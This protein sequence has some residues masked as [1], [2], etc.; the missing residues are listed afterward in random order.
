MKEL[1]PRE[2]KAVMALAVALGLTA[3]VLA[4][5]FWPASAAAVADASPQS[6]PQIEQRLARVRDIAATVPAG[7]CDL[8]TRHRHDSPRVFGLVDSDL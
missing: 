4:Y 7:E 8:R 2:K 3:V 6:V 5:E 1:E